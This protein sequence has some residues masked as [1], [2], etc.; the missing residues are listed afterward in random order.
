MTCTGVSLNGIYDF[1][2][3]GANLIKH[4][5]FVYTY[6]SWMFDNTKA[7]HIEPNWH[8]HKQCYFSQQMQ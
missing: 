2:F 4:F 6:D 5:F 7:V 1:V 8:K 3:H